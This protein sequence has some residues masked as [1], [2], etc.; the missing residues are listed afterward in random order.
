MAAKL[1]LVYGTS[2]SKDMMHDVW[3]CVCRD[4]LHESA[5]EAA[6]RMRQSVSLL[7]LAQRVPM[8][9]AQPLHQPCLL[10]H[11]THG[12]SKL[13]RTP[14]CLFHTPQLCC[15][16]PPS[17]PDRNGDAVCA[18]GQNGCPQR[19]CSIRTVRNQCMTAKIEQNRPVMISKKGIAGCRLG[20]QQQRC[21]RACL[22]RVAGPE[23]ARAGGRA[24]TA[25]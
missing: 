13:P 8:A 4:R 1:M 14:V 19:I 24:E 3:C 7:S 2:T 11:C 9:A 12:Y 10:A 20:F 23:D 6:R 17:K 18:Q 5:P 22:D 21:H 16:G 25:C 15:W